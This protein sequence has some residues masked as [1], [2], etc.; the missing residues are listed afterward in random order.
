MTDGLVNMVLV[1]GPKKQ[2]KCYLCRS[3]NNLIFIRHIPN[4]DFLLPFDLYLCEH[5]D[6]KCRAMNEKE[7]CER[8]LNFHIYPCLLKHYGYNIHDIYHKF[9]LPLETIPKWVFDDQ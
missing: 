1:A 6:Q 5:C 2:S 4:S 7:L 3:E 8:V 9:Q